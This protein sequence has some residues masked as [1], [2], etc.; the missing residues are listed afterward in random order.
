LGDP[1]KYICE[2]RIQKEIFDLTQPNGDVYNRYSFTAKEG[3]QSWQELEREWKEFEKND[4]KRDAATGEALVDLIFF[5]AN[6]IENMSEF[7][8][9]N[10]PEDGWKVE[11]VV[12]TGV[13]MSK[14]EAVKIKIIS[15]N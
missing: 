3:E 9:T 11:F 13:D 7:C 8:M 14:V 5:H 4:M 1:H 2:P 6:E 10:E 15:A 12:E